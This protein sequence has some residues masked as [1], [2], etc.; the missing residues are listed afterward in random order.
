MLRH[1]LFG[2]YRACATKVSSVSISSAKPATI[3]I[4]MPQCRFENV[5]SRLFLDLAM[6]SARL[7][8]SGLPVIRQESIPSAEL[9]S[10][11]PTSHCSGG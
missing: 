8:V 2:T 11:K 10:D 3:R 7:I 1:C 9:T 6:G 4:C 5:E